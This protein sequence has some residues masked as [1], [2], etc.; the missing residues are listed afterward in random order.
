ML[1]ALQNFGFDEKSISI[2]YPPGFSEKSNGHMTIFPNPS[3]GGS[4]VLGTEI[5]DEKVSLEILTT[6]GKILYQGI[7]R[8]DKGRTK[9]DPGNLPDGMYVLRLRS[10]TT[11][12]IEKLVISR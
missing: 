5:A 8:L 3:R 2:I 12:L 1:D 9:V 6:D 10:S 4:F 7:H 11:V